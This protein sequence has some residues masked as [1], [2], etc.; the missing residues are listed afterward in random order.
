MVWEIVKVHINEGPF[1]V[2]TVA[3]YPQVITVSR[4]LRNVPRRENL[5]QHGWVNPWVCPCPAVH[6]PE[7]YNWSDPERHQ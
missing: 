4:D 6:D 1:F 2:G 3:N 7:V 5:A